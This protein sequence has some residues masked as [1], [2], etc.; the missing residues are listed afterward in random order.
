MFSSVMG[1]TCA[2]S[3]TAPPASL[4]APLSSRCDLEIETSF[5]MMHRDQFLSH[6]QEGTGDEPWLHPS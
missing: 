4:L 5:S 2:C 1:H 6:R 3:L